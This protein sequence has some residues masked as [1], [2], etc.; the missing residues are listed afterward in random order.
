LN[1]YSIYIEQ[2]EIGFIGSYEFNIEKFELENLQF[3][4]VVLNDQVLLQN[5]KYRN[6][7]TRFK[8]KET[9]ITYQNSYEF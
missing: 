8:R 7:N 2:K 5:I 4:L 9:L 6:Y 1:T 3:E